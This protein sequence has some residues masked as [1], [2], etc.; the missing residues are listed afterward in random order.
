[1]NKKRVYTS[2]EGGFLM[3]CLKILPLK[4]RNR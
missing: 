2:L 4:S 1:M 3:N